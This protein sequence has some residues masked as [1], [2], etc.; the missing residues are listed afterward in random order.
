MKQAHA[1]GIMAEGKS[2][3]LTGPAGSGKTYVLNQF[4][5]YARA[6]GKK[7]AVT[8]ST[9][10]AATHLGGNTIHSWAGIGIHDE[11]K[12]YMISDM[13]KTRRDQITSADILVIDEVSMLHD[14]R[15][16]MV[17]E[18]CR[19]VRE[20]DRPFGGL[21][22]IL[23]G[24]FYQLPPINRE[25][26]RQGGFIVNSEAWENLEPIICYL[27][28]Q[29]RQ[30]DDQLLEILT[31]LRD[32]D[33]RRRHAESLLARKMY[34]T[35]F[36]EVVTEL[37][38]RN[39]NVDRINEQKLSEMD[40]DLHEFTMTH[41]GRTSGVESLMKSCLAPEV[42]MLKQ[43]AFVMFVKNSLEKKYVNGTLGTVVNFENL[44]G[45]PIVQTKDGR[46]VTAKPD[47][48]ELRDG[49]KKIASISQIPLRLAWAI[50]VH[51]SQGMTL[52]GAHIDLSNAFVPGMGYVALSRVKKLETLTLGGL[53][54][55]ALTMSPEATEIDAK[56]RKQSTIHAKNLSHLEKTWSKLSKKRPKVAKNSGDWNAKM[57]K[58]REKYPNAYMPWSDLDDLRLIKKFTE[59]KTIKD[60]TESFGRH[61]GSISARLEKLLGE[62]WNDTSTL[63]A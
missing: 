46:L 60:L 23:C 36:D 5:K 63:K 34:R 41:S 59:G 3:F 26:G 53:N 16:D 18:V 37:Y 13:S 6:Q 30:E 7:V 9:G 51:K 57:A 10:L 20:D 27:E 15:L 32:N 21:Q 56:L 62:N 47:T 4:V 14:Y 49:E 52:D 42:L 44:T 29:H 12:K 19:K 61:P 54:K 8:A 2:V 33:L 22:V 45:Y 24:D 38:T 35:P 58:M 25:D 43:G 1:L 55:M 28:E 50:T 39:E 11:V 40:G 48:W 17:E 31:A